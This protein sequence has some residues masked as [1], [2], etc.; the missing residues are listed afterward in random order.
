MIQR[1]LIANRAEIAARIARTA[2]R[3]GIDTVAVYSEADRDALHVDAADQAVA[4]GGRTPS[5]SY[6]RA[7]AIIE[8]ARR[9]GCDSVHPGYGFLAESAD[10][11]RTVIDAGLTWVGPTPDQIAMLGDKL[12]ARR[13][14]VAAGVPT[15]E[16][17]EVGADGAR[18]DVEL[19]F[20]AL[21]KAAAGGGG[22]GM[23]LVRREGDLD[24]AIDA[25]RREAQ[26]AFGDGTVFIEPYLE[27]VRHVEVQIIGDR[28]GAVVHLGERECSI[29]RRNQKLI[30]EAPSPGIDERTRCALHTW[31]LALA[32]HVGYEN[33]GTV[34]FL[35]GE[36]GAIQFLEVNTRLQV[37]HPV[38]EATTGLDLVELQLRVAAGE[39]LGLN[40]GDVVVRGHAIEA[41]VVA[42]DPAA[43]WL[44]SAGRVYRFAVPD[45]VRV[46]AGVRDDSIV[47][48]DYDSLLAKVIAHAPNRRSAA[49]ELATAL[50]ETALHGP[51]TNVAM[52]VATLGE[53]SFAEGATYTSY[54]DEHPDV[55]ARTDDGWLTHL[56]AVVLDAERRH[57][58]ADG[59]WG[60]APSG[61]RNLR[62]QPQ[63]GVW[64]RL[65]AAEPATVEYVIGGDR[66]SGD[67]N[68]EVVVRVDG[69]EHLV[70][71]RHASDGSV[72]VEVDGVRCVVSLHHVGDTVWTN[73]QGAQHC[74]EPVDRFGDHG[75]QA[76]LS[77]PVAP[78]PGTIVAVDVAAGDHVE[79]GATLVVLE[80]MKMEHRITAAA[81]ALVAEVRVAPGDRVDAG[82]VLVRFE[83]TG[84]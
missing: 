41:R 39:P 25:A 73:G 38:T 34:E 51:A 37:E 66:A 9:T 36:D 31:A 11:A 81:D 13:A 69:I 44:P 55:L 7:E 46:D 16:A 5:E 1:L 78:L 20:P 74:F 21:V 54:L 48:P 76:S 75:S 19:R 43:G 60:F 15:S 4:L 3:L 56:I 2:R 26:A 82:E 49:S 23:R 71:R 35:V 57:R 59:L 45:T 62:T 83:E 61:W 72:A 50:G 79:E 84:N 63:R 65:G 47:S 28:H 29:Q 80:A 18:R 24:D 30:E 40:Q 6:L 10:F 17:I 52:L 68:G 67:D 42:E 64:R 12:A 27:R 70:R 14:A 77:G 32:S 53:P 33:A 22:R 58:H 8:A